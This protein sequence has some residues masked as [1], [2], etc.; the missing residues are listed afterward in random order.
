MRIKLNELM[1]TEHLEQDLQ[2]ASTQHELTAI[3]IT[4]ITISE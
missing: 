3:I 2:T 1:H 4:I